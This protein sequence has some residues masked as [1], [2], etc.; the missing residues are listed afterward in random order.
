MTRKAVEPVVAGTIRRA[1]AT[2]SDTLLSLF[3]LRH[4]MVGRSERLSAQGKFSPAT[5][6]ASNLNRTA[7]GPDHNPGKADPMRED[8]HRVVAD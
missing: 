5:R 4:R 7:F 2:G 6:H 1:A 3:S 8:R